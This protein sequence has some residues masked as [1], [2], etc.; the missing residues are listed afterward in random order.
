LSEPQIRIFRHG[1]HVAIAEI[2]PRAIH[3]IASQAYSPEQ[4]LAWSAREPNYERWKVRCEF[5]RPFVAVVDDQIA[6]FLELDTNGHIDCA[7]I[8]PDF[9]RRG[10]MTRLVNHAV[11]TC[12]AMKIDRVFVEA[13]ICARPMFEKTGFTVVRDNVVTVKEV[14]LINYI[15]E[16]WCESPDSH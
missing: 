6:G 9:Q 4:C 12:F 7:Y 5:K 3:E 8:S 15:M 13:S 14:S 1:D 11:E 2:F 16:K 10:I